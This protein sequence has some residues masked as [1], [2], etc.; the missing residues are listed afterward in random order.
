[1]TCW[2]LNRV[3]N[4]FL[5][6]MGWSEIFLCSISWFYKEWSKKHQISSKRQFSGWLQRSKENDRT[7]S[8]WQEGNSN[9]KRHLLQLKSAEEHLFCSRRVPLLSTI[10]RK[11]RLQIIDSPK[12]DN[13][14]WKNTAWC[15]ESWRLCN[16]W[17]VGSEFASLVSVIQAAGG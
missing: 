2:S 9:S 4:W 10:N 14:R 17:M 15:D 13:R 8:S 12:V 3:K 16:T 6:S 1:M 5:C 7:G 11:L